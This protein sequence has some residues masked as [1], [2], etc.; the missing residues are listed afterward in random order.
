MTLIISNNAQG[1]PEWFKDR[2]GKA[3][4]SKAS[5]ICSKGRTKVTESTTRENYRYQLALERING[6]SGEVEFTNRHIERGKELEEW[7][8]KSYE[9]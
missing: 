7:A 8:R 1:T 5:V 9:L 3:T 4:G 2:L 6:V